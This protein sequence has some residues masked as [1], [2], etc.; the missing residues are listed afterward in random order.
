MRLYSGLAVFILSMSCAP[1]FG[2]ARTPVRANLALGEKA[3][4]QMP[5]WFEPNL[6]QMDRSVRFAA[7][8]AHGRLAIHQTGARLSYPQGSLELNLAGADRR[9]RHVGE[10]TQLA[11]TNYLLGNRADRWKM[12]V[13]HFA[14]VR[15]NQP[16]PGID[17]AYYFN[18][19]RFEYDLVVAPGADPN[20]IRLKFGGARAT[21]LDSDGA[22]RFDL[23]GVE[24]RQ[25]APVAYQWIGPNRVSVD[26]RYKMAANGEVRIALGT[27]DKAATLVIDPIIYAG[28]TKGQ[29]NQIV[30]AVALDKSGNIW[31]AG[32]AYGTVDV[33][34]LTEPYKNYSAAYRDAFVAEFAI[35][36]DGQLKLLYWS[37]VGASD[38]EEAT[39]L[40]VNANGWVYVAGE[41]SSSDFP[42]A[43][44]KLQSAIGGGVDAFLFVIDPS[45]AG[46]SS[47]IYSSLWGGD[48]NETVR[49]MALDKDGNVVV[50]GTSASQVLP[51]VSYGVQGSNRG[52]WDVYLF[53]V[54]P[55]PGS[56]QT[57][58]YS[59]FFGG[60]S[61]D[62]ATGVALDAAGNIYFTGYTFS[63]DFPTTG[64]AWQQASDQG[65]GDAFIVKLDINRSGLDAL[66]YA[67]VIG[68]TD[69]DFANSIDVDANGFVWITG[70][71]LSVDFPTTANA[72]Q[73]LYAGGVDGF[74]VRFDA[75]GTASNP[76][77]YSTY[78]GGSD[79]DVPNALKVL[80]DGR[81]AVAGYTMSTDMPGRGNSPTVQMVDAFV[82]VLDPS[83]SGAAGLVSTTLFG[84]AYVEAITGLT[85]DASGN[86]YAAGSSYSFDLPT[87]DGSGKPGEGG[88]PSGF[89]LKIKP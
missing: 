38:Y 72:A 70:Y 53:K 40:A 51:G 56:S 41:T 44:T 15:W 31:I 3:I 69:L 42:T 37:Y 25:L 46:T 84:G 50:V 60:G 88:Q 68:G 24:V 7:R 30:R 21:H 57:L 63:S 11:R 13:P 33:T 8:S 59:T 79:A 18:D 29:E 20:R 74:V 45:V 85:T 80:P 6:G 35:A 52:G 78:L 10:Q 75:N 83:K 34:D 61:T 27:Y 39:A 36:E 32:S 55:K 82:T 2:A 9:A 81:V 54:D 76:L 65:Y 62:I 73:P 14:R 58:L 87:T 1:V 5:A 49:G 67:T 64:N 22:L 48:K 19:S 12:G 71:T 17:V 23:G 43:G 86:I 66:V 16:Y 47:L 28:Y 77:L 89:L 26:A 4:G